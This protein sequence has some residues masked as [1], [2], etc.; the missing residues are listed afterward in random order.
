[1]VAE[2]MPKTVRKR[3]VNRGKAAQLRVPGLDRRRKGVVWWME[4][5]RTD[6]EEDWREV[7]IRWLEER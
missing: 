7:M 5:E 1:M 3:K 6:Q 2:R 4:G